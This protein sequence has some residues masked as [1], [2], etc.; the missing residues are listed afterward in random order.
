MDF[1][2]TL[3]SKRGGKQFSIK[4]GYVVIS[5]GTLHFV[6]Y[7]ADK[8]IK[9]VGY[10]KGGLGLIIEKQ[11]KTNKW[12]YCQAIRKF[13]EKDI[14]VNLQATGYKFRINAE[15]IAENEYVFMFDNAKMI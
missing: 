14:P 12:K 10:V 11:D 5:D 2:K 13:E 15:K 3:N 1:I 4:Y 6:M 7:G 8:V 9:Q